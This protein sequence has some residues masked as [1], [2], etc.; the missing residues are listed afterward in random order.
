MIIRIGDEKQEGRD[1]HLN[2]LTAFMIENEESL[3][4]PLLD[5]IGKTTTALTHKS[6]FYSSIVA[7]FA[8]DN[9]ILAK[10]MCE[11]VLEK[12]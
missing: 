10:E 4:Y 7:N 11:A 3:H 1:E 9:E 8:T 2:K 12:M 6:L 5:M